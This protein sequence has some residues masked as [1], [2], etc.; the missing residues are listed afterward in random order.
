MYASFYR[1]GHIY[2]RFSAVCWRSCSF[3]VRYAGRG[4]SIIGPGKRARTFH[5]GKDRCRWG[6]A[7][8]DRDRQQGH[9][10]SGNTQRAGHQR[11]VLRAGQKKTADLMQV[12][13]LLLSCSEIAD[14]YVICPWRSGSLYWTWCR[15]SY[16]AGIPCCPAG[17]WGRVS[18]ARS[19]RGSVHRPAGAGLPCAC[20]Y[21]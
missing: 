3:I 21:G 5:T 16:P 1:Q 2:V 4:G 18:C 8:G 20:P 6:R 19:R 7:P 13:R 14:G 11:I 15:A 17:S 9:M 10:Y 12:R